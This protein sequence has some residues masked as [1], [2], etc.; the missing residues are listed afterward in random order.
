M[1]IVIHSE[2][3][4]LKEG[5]RSLPFKAILDLSQPSNC[6]HVHSNLDL[7][8]GWMDISRPADLFLLLNLVWLILTGL[9]LIKQMSQT[10]VICDFVPEYYQI[11]CHAFCKK[12]NYNMSYLHM[13]L[14]EV[15]GYKV[16]PGVRLHWSC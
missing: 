13:S 9:Y 14:C 2:H 5:G 11:L 10:S 8:K 16:H 4:F 6:K 1:W 15:P 3:L 7:T 12:G